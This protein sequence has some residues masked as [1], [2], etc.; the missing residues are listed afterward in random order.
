TGDTGKEEKWRDERGPCKR[1]D[2]RA[3]G[4]RQ[5][6]DGEHRQGVLQQIV[7]ECGKELAPEQRG[8]PPGGHQLRKHWGTCFNCL[9]SIRAT[10]ANCGRSPQFTLCAVKNA[11]TVWRSRQWTPYQ[12]ALK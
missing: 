11:S 6:I 2:G 5:L 9:P 8:E 4:H 10:E 7:V 12:L 1:A 3:V